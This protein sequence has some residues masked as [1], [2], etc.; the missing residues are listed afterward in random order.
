MMNLREAGKI[1]MT[2]SSNCEWLDIGRAD[3][4]ET[5]IEEFQLSRDKYLRN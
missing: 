3:D 4:Y 2:Y 1:V 5:A